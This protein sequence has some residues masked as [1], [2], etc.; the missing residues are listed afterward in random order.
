MC[1]KMKSKRRDTAED[2]KGWSF[3]G[4]RMELGKESTM[5]ERVCD[6]GLYSIHSNKLILDNQIN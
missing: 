4:K 2:T 6:N 3:P 1:R 5:E